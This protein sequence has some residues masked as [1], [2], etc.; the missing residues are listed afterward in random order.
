MMIEN[1]VEIASLLAR[2][3]PLHHMSLTSYL[4]PEDALH[5]LSEKDYDLVI[6]DLLVSE[7]DGLEVC[8]KIRDFSN[9]PIMISSAR[10]DIQQKLGALGLGV[11]DY[12]PRPCDPRELIT[13]IQNVISR[14]VTLKRNMF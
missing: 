4:T 7:F 12:L 9:I 14:S 8:R 6:L 2:I 13:R 5:A 1:D 10:S 3:L 11:D